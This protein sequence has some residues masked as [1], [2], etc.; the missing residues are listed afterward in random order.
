MPIAWAARE[1]GPAEPPSRKAKYANP[2]SSFKSESSGGLVGAV[3]GVYEGLRRLSPRFARS[4]SLT[5]RSDRAC[6]ASSRKKD[7]TSE[8][9]LRIRE[10]MPLASLRRVV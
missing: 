8:S 6:A 2:R 5:Q 9:E 7:E 1:R 4:E 10:L 3:R